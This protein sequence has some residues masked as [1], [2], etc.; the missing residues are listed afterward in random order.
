LLYSALG[1]FA[2]LENVGSLYTSPHILLYVSL[3][4]SSLSAKLLGCVCFCWDLGR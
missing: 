2:L 4:F 3:P 1:S